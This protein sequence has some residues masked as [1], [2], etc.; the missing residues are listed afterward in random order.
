MYC[1]LPRRYTYPHLLLSLD[2]SA[3]ETY[4]L[5]RSGLPGQHKFYLSLVIWNPTRYELFSGPQFHN[6]LFIVAR[7]KRK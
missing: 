3:I 7:I 6:A 4:R 2:P 5:D 1:S